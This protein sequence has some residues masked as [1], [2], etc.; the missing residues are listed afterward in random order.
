M[1]RRP[2]PLIPAAAL[3]LLLS[4]CAARQPDWDL[5]ISGLVME[6]QSLS[7]VSAARL[8]VP[9][10]GNFVSC[11]NIPPGGACSTL[12]PETGYTGNPVEVSWSQNGQIWSTGELT[13]N[14]GD[15]VLDEGRAVVMVVIAA[16]GAAGVQLIPAGGSP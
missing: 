6:N 10:T 12:F 2:G 5:Q 11:G 13:L 9:A 7:Y 1:T 3:T 16:P 4:A 8:I 14:P 15:A